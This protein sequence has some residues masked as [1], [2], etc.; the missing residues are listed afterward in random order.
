MALLFS[1]TLTN[2]EIRRH[3][4]YAIGYMAYKGKAKDNYGGARNTYDGIE[5]RLWFAGAC[6]ALDEDRGH[7]S[8][9][10]KN[11]HCGPPLGRVPDPEQLPLFE[12]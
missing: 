2:D 3:P 8:T 10:W 11:D 4:V 6:C 9:T 7:E 1:G 12:V 5:S